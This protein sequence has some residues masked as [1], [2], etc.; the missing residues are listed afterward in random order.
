M[1]RLR[2]IAL[3]AFGVV[4]AAIGYGI[5]VLFLSLMLAGG[6]YRTEC[7]LENG[8]HTKGWDLGDSVPPRLKGSSQHRSVVRETVSAPDLSVS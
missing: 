1:G 2:A 8:T 5:G 4:A 6:V 3:A 7:T